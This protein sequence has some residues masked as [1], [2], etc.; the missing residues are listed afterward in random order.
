M[1]Y[2]DPQL[3]HLDSML[4]QISVG[5]DNDALVGD[6]LFPAVQV[7]KQSD[8]YYVLEKVGFT[9]LQDTAAPNSATPEVPP[10][11]LSRDSYYAE[12]HRLKGWVSIDEIQ[13]ADNPMDPLADT[14]EQVTDTILLN[15]EDA[16]QTLARTAANYA[17]GFSTTLSGT[18]QW[19][20][21]TNSTPI[22]DLKAARDAIHL[23]IFKF[24]TL[25]ILGYEVATKLED[26][27]DF[28]DRIKANPNVQ[29]NTLD[30][31]GQVVGIPRLI[32]AGAGK[33][34]A[35][36]GQAQS[37]SYMWGK[38]VVIAYVPAN[39]GK[40]VPAFG[41]EFAWRFEG[42]PMPTDRW[43]DQDRKSWAVRTTRRYDLKFTAVDAVATGKATGGYVIKT[44]VA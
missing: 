30:T 15:R 41:Y 35:A 22:V 1:A 3:V 33:N 28:L 14:T 11:T 2:N 29:V 4:T 20:D 25:S 43:Y 32:R 44:A 31:I 17:S 36:V 10:M 38:D 42:S 27:P 21:Y 16:I 8:K 7:D 26:H 24:P 13:N 19:S 9:P 5:Y 12:E 18:S 34:T 6:M 40:K 39:P 23:G 37:I